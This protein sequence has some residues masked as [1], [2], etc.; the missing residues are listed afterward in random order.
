M[1]HFDSII[2]D[3]DGTLW[4]A[5]VTCAEAWNI[6]LKNAG[7]IGCEVT[8]DQIR[9]V[10]GLPFEECVGVLFRGLPQDTIERLAVDIDAQ[11]SAALRVRGGQLYENVAAGIRELA[12]RYKL[13]IVSN[14]QSWYLQLFLD[15]HDMRQNFLAS[16]CHGDMSLDKKDMISQIC[17]S[18]SLQFP[19]YIG[20]TARDQLAS[21]Q[22]GVKF[23]F[24]SYGFGHAD[25]PEYTF[26]SFSQLTAWFNSGKAA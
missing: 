2:F 24:A 8:A 5:S 22:A 4:D 18:H 21:L 9:E 13:F 17:G 3:L 10:S 7:I 12:Q 26:S 19:I 16:S 11:E 15:Q 14:C 6:A 23:G 25:Q 20:D 1:H